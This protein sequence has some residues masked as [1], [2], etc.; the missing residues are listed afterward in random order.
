MES[1]QYDDYNGLTYIAR[2][3]YRRCD[4]LMKTAFLS[5]REQRLRRMDDESDLVDKATT[6]NSW[7]DL[8]TIAVGTLRSRTLNLHAY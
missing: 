2:K 5:H 3:H 1:Q 7:Q 8:M 4:N 6:M